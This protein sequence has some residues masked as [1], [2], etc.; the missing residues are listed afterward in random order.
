MIDEAWRVLGPNR[1]ASRFEALRGGGISPLVGRQAEML[2]LLPTPHLMG[3]D[4][5]DGLTTVACVLGAAFVL[6]R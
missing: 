2:L 1:A 3:L 6:T 4:R 5:I